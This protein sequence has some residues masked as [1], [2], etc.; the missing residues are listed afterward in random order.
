MEDDMFIISPFFPNAR[1]RQKDSNFGF[2]FFTFFDV[3]GRWQVVIKISLDNCILW[4]PVF[5]SSL[6]AFSKGLSHYSLEGG[7]I[8]PLLTLV[9]QIRRGKKLTL[10]Y[11]LLFG[12]RAPYSGDGES[13]GG[14]CPEWPIPTLF[15]KKK[16]RRKEKKSFSFWPCPANK[17]LKKLFFPRWQLLSNRRQ[18]GKI[19]T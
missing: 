14:P 12:G 10:L 5:L 17:D 9:R 19:N 16:R 6:D 2:D 8:Y 13:G 15:R 7:P 11:P 3:C 4:K 1:G 18:S